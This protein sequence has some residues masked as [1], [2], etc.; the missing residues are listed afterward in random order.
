[1]TSQ[2]PQ[3]HEMIP[4]NTF[5]L[6]EHCTIQQ[7]TV[8]PTL[9][10]YWRGQT[11]NFYSPNPGTDEVCRAGENEIQNLQ[12]SR[13]F[14][15][16]WSRSREVQPNLFQTDFTPMRY[17]QNVVPS[18][19]DSQYGFASNLSERQQNPYS[20]IFDPP[21][22]YYNS[23]KLFL[24][25]NAC[26]SSQSTQSNCPT[27]SQT[28]FSCD[29]SNHSNS[30]FVELN[31]NNQP[32][33]LSSTRENC[34]VSDIEGDADSQQN[35]NH[36]LHQLNIVSRVPRQNISNLITESQV[37]SIRRDCES[38]ENEYHELN[39]SERELEKKN[40]V[41]TLAFGFDNTAFQSNDQNNWRNA[42]NE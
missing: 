11:G 39:F 22:P 16:P 35:H 20:V 41:K 7:A 38:P 15:W 13:L 2:R 28:Y 1:V 42:R 10:L 27:P 3:P 40:R 21:P 12:R 5:G 32:S 14:N 33:N 18:G 19:A 24:F 37:E 34:S 4:R 26:P 30:S 23:N 9:S 29:H 6:C 17:P 31:R 25:S 36:H 8:T